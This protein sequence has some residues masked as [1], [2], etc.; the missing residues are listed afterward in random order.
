[1]QPWPP[2]LPTF[3]ADM[4]IADAD[5]RD[6]ALLAAD[7][8][9]AIAYVER[10]RSDVD[11]TEPVGD[12][13]F[14]GTLMEA[15]RLFQRRKS[16]DGVVNLGQLGTGRVPGWDADLEKLLGVGRFAPMRFA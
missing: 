12:D 9:A 15:A 4:R 14:K 1:M 13:L 6:D 11:F 3:K 7:L 5:E 16:P 2:D 10:V 8:A